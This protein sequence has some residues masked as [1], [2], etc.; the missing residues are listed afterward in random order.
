MLRNAAV[1]ISPILTKL[2]NLSLS[3]GK[4]PHKWKVSSVVSIPK[5][6]AN[7]DN[8]CNYRPISLLLIVSKLFEKHV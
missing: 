7:I 5:S 6:I 3:T 1:S 8:P 4:I 2:F